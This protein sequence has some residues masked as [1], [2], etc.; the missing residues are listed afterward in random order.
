MQS[1]CYRIMALC[2]FVLACTCFFLRYS[3]AL[4]V[5][6][7]CAQHKSVPD[8]TE[9]QSVVTT[10]LSLSIM[11]F[12]LQKSPS[13][14]LRPPGKPVPLP[15]DP[16]ANMNPRQRLEARKARETPWLLDSEKSW[17]CN[18]AKKKGLGLFSSPAYIPERLPNQRQTAN[19]TMVRRTAVPYLSWEGGERGKTYG[20]IGLS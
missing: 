10:K 16:E 2:V 17:R 20:T 15:P 4:N 5:N 13:F 18:P 19:R 8:L 7:G 3:F 9:H 6:Q 1:M 11:E 14:P 12:D